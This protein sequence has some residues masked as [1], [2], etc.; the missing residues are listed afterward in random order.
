MLTFQYIPWEDI[1]NLESEKKV[2]KLLRIV[3]QEKIIMMEGRLSSDEEAR[4]IE[5]TMELIDSKF[6]GVEVG[7]VE[8]NGNKNEEVHEKLRSL[9]MN[10]FLGRRRGLTI[11]GPAHIVKEIKKDPNR[12]QLF[13]ANPKKRRR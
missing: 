4:L 8:P 5:A 11:I 13:M 2:Q 6:K 12:L 9:F 3:K 1:C 10:L 7:M